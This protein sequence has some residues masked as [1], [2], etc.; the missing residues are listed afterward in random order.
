MSTGAVD[1]EDTEESGWL[2][3]HVPILHWLPRYDRSWLRNDVIAGLSVWALM[4]P[5]SLGYA[6]ISGVPVEY[7]LYAAAIGLILFAVFTTSRQV[8]EGPS[9]STAAVLGASVLAFAS[10][11]SD[12]AIAMAAAI[13]FVAGLLFILMWVLK[14]GWVSDFLSAA[15]LTGFTFGVGINVAVGELFKVTGTE[16]DGDNTWQKFG[17]WISE[18]PDTHGTTLVVGALALALLFGLKLFVPRVPGALV[19]VVLGIAAT[20][21]FDLEEEGVEM[22]ADVPRG[23]P[24]LVLPDFEFI[25]DN[26][27][28]IV[29]GAVALL[30]I[31]FS[32]TTAAVRQYAAKHSY[33]I[34]IDQE[35]LA[36]GMA[37][38][39]SGLVQGVFNN[40]SLSKSPVNDEAG[41]RSQVSNLAQGVFIIL[42][43]LFLAPLF[44]NLP[45][46]VLGAIIIEAVVMGMMDVPEM[47]RLYRVKRFEFLAALAALLG[48]LTF[49][50][51]EGV[52]IGAVLSLIWIVAVSSRPVIPEL[53]RKPGTEAF[54]DLDHHPEGETYSGLV[55]IRFDGGLIYVNAGGLADRVRD[56]RVHSADDLRGLVLSMEGV[57]YIDTEGA[58]AVSKIAQAGIEQD[59]EV[60]LARVKPEVLEV[61]Q[62]DG[63]LELIG[64]DH[65]HANIDAAV[66][67]YLSTHPTEAHSRGNEKQTPEEEDS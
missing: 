65:I 20:A 56:I 31:G 14:M 3:R 51:L 45:Q 49:G 15:V 34:D 37:N 18:L 57:N 4:V 63:A 61:L 66:Y 36:Q 38:V 13:V 27:E 6:S 50:I 17:E 54:Y 60:Y 29:A 52:V 1:A 39:G 53:G 23:L 59:V 32:V 7:G 41:A 55:V 21:I 24:A 46:A 35:L 26:L 42:T 62:R 30:L 8:T 48:V 25:Y 2:S 64:A 22:V 19:A 44:S 40:G 9:S 47:A 16:K 11:G 10:A 5:T 33:R 58:D 43:L 67:M 28:T 12:E